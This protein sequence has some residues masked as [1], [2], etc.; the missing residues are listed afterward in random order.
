MSEAPPAEDRK[1]ESPY[2][3]TP[4][5]AWAL[6][7]TWNLYVTLESIPAVVDLN[8]AIEELASTAGY[9]PTPGV[10]SI[11]GLLRF[12]FTFFAIDVAAWFIIIILQYSAAYGL[13]KPKRWARKAGITS[14]GLGLIM[15]IAMLI[16]STAMY[17]TL[18]LE[19]LITDV[20]PVVWNTVAFLAVW[21]FLNNPETRSYID[22]EGYAKPMPLMV[23]EEIKPKPA[24]LEK[25]EVEP[26]VSIDQ[27]PNMV[28]EK[29]PESVAWIV[30]ANSVGE[31]FLHEDH[32]IIVKSRREPVIDIPIKDI[33][34]MERG[35]IRF[36]AAPD[37]VA[38][39]DPS[40]AATTGKVSK[41]KIT[42]LTKPGLTSTITFAAER[43]ICPRC[44]GKMSLVAAGWYCIKDDLIIDPATNDLAKIIESKR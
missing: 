6:F 7:A 32:L 24:P 30:E 16:L 3:K 26:T 33:T 40:I 35:K 36:L 4:I 42:Y 23:E 22:S 18:E 44:S 31:I 37:M 9:V 14:V 41:L 11:L 8:L 27:I 34:N 38:A 15:S 39:I 10:P 12:F 25:A 5:I 17:M 20:I 43:K 28:R 29:R 1:M 2:G 19:I 13:W 21:R